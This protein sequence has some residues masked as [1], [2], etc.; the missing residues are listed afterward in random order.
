MLWP[1][2]HRFDYN[3]LNFGHFI[4]RSYR[5]GG[6][7]LNQRWVLTAA[8]CFCND[9][10]QCAWSKKKKRLEP[11]YN[12]HAYATMYF[13][14]NIAQVAKVNSKRFR[15]IQK[16]IIHEG[17]ELTGKMGYLSRID[18]YIYVFQI[19]ILTMTWLC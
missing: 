9:K 6:T 3:S 18:K 2:K 19:V 1:N 5:C 14:T 16:V 8:H 17:F 11:K 4:C 12:V 10:N 13:G 7:L 15:G